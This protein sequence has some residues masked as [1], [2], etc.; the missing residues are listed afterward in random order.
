MVCLQIRNIS[1]ILNLVALKFELIKF[2]FEQLA[3]QF[4]LNSVHNDM[5]GTLIFSV[6][7]QSGCQVDR[8]IPGYLL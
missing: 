5:Q 2:L 1:Q 6:G 7:S 8:H 4:A 3:Q